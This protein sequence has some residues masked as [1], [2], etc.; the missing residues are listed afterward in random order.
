MLAL[1]GEQD[2]NLDDA[3]RLVNM[4]IIGH[5]VGPGRA[6]QP[7]QVGPR[8]QGARLSG[9]PA[10]CRGESCWVLGEGELG[11]TTRGAAGPALQVQL[12][13]VAARC[14]PLALAA[15][16][17]RPPRA[18]ERP[19]MPLQAVIPGGQHAFYVDDP[20]KF[21]SVVGT[22]L[23]WACSWVLHDKKL[24]ASLDLQV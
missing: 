5:K 7:G 19:C 8:R 9:P 1:Y 21:H 4:F 15:A 18:S 10:A 20:D 12:A 24:P 2:P 14:G 11:A 17:G 6:G 22:Y 23:K 13:R 3:Q 16:V